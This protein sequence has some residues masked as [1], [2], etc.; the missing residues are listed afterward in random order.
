MIMSDFRGLLTNNST[1]RDDDIYQLVSTDIHFQ[2]LILMSL[3]IVAGIV[4]VGAYA[5]VNGCHCSGTQLY[6]YSDH[7]IQ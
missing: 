5:Y 7:E 3:G 1:A 6:S 4:W 2:V